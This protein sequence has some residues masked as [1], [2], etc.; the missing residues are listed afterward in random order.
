M[1]GSVQKKGGR[2]YVK[3]ELDSDPGT[4]RR[5]Q[6]WHSGFSTR[7]EAERARR[8]GLALDTGTPTDEQHH[9]H[10][11]EVEASEQTPSDL[12]AVLRRARPSTQPQPVATHLAPA[13]TDDPQSAPAQLQDLDRHIRS[14]TG[15]LAPPD[16]NLTPG[17]GHRHTAHIPPSKPGLAPGVRKGRTRIVWAFSDESERAA[18]MLVGVVMVAP[19]DVH[20]ARTTMRSL[21][22][23]GQRRVH[24]TD[25]SP[26]RRHLILDTVARTDGLSAVVLRY[27]RPEGTHK[28]AGR[29]LLLQAATGLVVGSGVTA[30]TL[31]DQEPNQKSRDRASIA[32]ALTGVDR[33]LHPVYDHHRSSSEPLLWAADTIC[34][35]VGAGAHWRRR[36]QT[37]LTVRDVGS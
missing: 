7:R 15:R 12:R 23:P 21:L 28:P 11:L 34:W 30:W 33:R 1:S 37:I 3:I 4:G 16:P 14:L 20:D 19:G 25:E 29:H 31:D 5:R 27:R 10:S 2:W 18:V 32:H 22:L 6:K 13:V 36:I 9:A 24:T 26:R 17:T 35:A 8:P